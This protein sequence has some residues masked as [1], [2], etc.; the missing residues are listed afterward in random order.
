MAGLFD[1]FRGHR[2]R[3]DSSRSDETQRAAPPTDLWV[4]C[5]DCG[6]A[7]YRKVFQDN[8][9]VC[10]KCGFHHK[11]TA[12]ERLQ[13]LAD[14]GSFE[15]WDAGLLSANPLNFS[16]EYLD[17]LAADR[18]KTGLDD[19]VLSGKVVLGGHPAALA[20]MDFH[21]RGGSMGSVVGEKITRALER[22]V[23][24]RLP[25]IV[26]TS[27]GGARMQEGMLSLMQ[28]VRTS[29]A[30]RRM[31]QARLG[32]FTVLTD[33][34]T[35]GV[36]ASFA[37]L[38]DV[39]VAEPRAIIGFSGARVIEQT[40]RQKLPPGFQTAEFYQKHGFIDMVVPRNDLKATLARLIGMFTV[41]MLL[42]TPAREAS[43]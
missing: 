26:V 15:E 1:K 42:E 24:M 37:A 30:V 19:A 12:R 34:T 29:A 21:F 13:L 14:P 40:I 39:I 9:R 11:L 2:P 8:L 22:A 32:Y 17:K 5:S 38:G 43:S 16:Q 6:A 18:K 20:I 4:K 41:P 33:P 28:M 25:A 27:S 3:V 23:E 36:A 10:E 35:A 7:M 31:N